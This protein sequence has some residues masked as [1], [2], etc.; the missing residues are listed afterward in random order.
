MFSS[1]RKMLDNFLHT[2]D[3]PM[4]RDDLIDRAEQAGLPIQFMGLLQ[5]LEN[6]DYQS[7]EDVEETLAIHK[8]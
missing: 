1:E 6:R 8:A 7:A 4:G 3:F 2:L 5:R